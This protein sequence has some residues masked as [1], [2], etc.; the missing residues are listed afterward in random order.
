MKYTG[1]VTK[2]KSGNSVPSFNVYLEQKINGITTNSHM[3][4][5]SEPDFELFKSR[6]D[7][8]VVGGVFEDFYVLINEDD[9]TITFDLLS[10]ISRL[11]INSAVLLNILQSKYEVL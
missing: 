8:G 2:V 6:I 7:R 11:H 10:S 5:F 9:V 3:L 4:Q 1:R